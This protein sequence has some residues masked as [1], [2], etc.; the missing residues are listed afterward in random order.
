MM[1]GAANLDP[2][3]FPD[4]EKFDLD[5]NLADVRKHLA[6]GYGIH[7]CRGAPLSRI[8]ARLFLETVIDRLPN[9][10]FDGPLEKDHRIPIFNGIG[11]LPIAWDV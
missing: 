2:T 6:F 3:M 9:L 10:R 7:I 11:K 4:P 8:E 5:R 1:W